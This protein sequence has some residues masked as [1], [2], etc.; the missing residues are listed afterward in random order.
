MQVLKLKNSEHIPEHYTGIIEF[1]NGNKYWIKEGRCH[2][3]DGPALET[4]GG[5]REWLIDGKLHRLDG[6]AIERPNETKEWWVDNEFYDMDE[7]YFL[8]KEKEEGSVLFLKKEIGKYGLVWYK[9]LTENG[10]KEFPLV[11]GMTIPSE[12]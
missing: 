1:E 6:P 5:Y 8:M 9:F 10:I 3:T 7:I 11:P 2:R 4:L 12:E